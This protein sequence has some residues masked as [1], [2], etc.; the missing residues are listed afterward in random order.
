MM[1]PEPAQQSPP[2]GGNIKL[3]V[4]LTIVALVAAFMVRFQSIIAPLLL[5]FILTYLL[6]PLI[7]KLSN[8]TRLSWRMSVNIIYLVFVILLVAS[9]TMTGLALVQQLQS[10]IGVIERFIN[11]LPELV[12]DWSTTI[13]QI[14]P[15]QIDMSQ[16]L[17]FSN[18]E[19]WIQQVIS[20][21]RPVLGQAGGLLGT[22][23][24]ETATSVMWGFFIILL[25]Y[26]LLSDMGQVP[27]KLVDL[28][29]P[30]GYDD[31]F[32]R[33]G[34]ELARIWNAFLRGQ[35]ILFTLTVL[36]Y[37]VLLAILGVR[38]VL[39]IAVLAGFA[40]FV[41]YVGQW[42][43]WIV[44]I[45]V[46]L[47]QKSNY[48]GLEPLQYMLLVFVIAIILDQIF[49]GI[50]APRIMGQTLG[51]HPAAVLVAA[52]VAANLLGLLGVVL[53]APVLATLTFVGLYVARKMLSLEPWPEPEK[54]ADT[55]QYPWI[56]LV[57][58]LRAWLTTLRERLKRK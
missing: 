58:R 51:V 38:N 6:H 22:V 17:S 57:E 46:T 29:L 40:R 15:F 4:G 56:R 14:G 42:V 20:I 37:T 9:F 33:M 19:A 54:D 11:E 25:S 23:A 53:A 21:V 8:A 49:D 28:E 34:R 30:P 41:P 5:T 26:F 39:A 13:Y 27:D 24:T 52:I 31:D 36:V 48:F 55:V 47:F 32:R 12:L 3:V 43:T 10:L 2:W 45:L 1:T 18:L 7:T 16:Y 44:I 50:L 35:V